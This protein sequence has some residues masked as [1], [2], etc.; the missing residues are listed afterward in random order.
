LRRWTALVATLAAVSLA[1]GCTE[2]A[3]SDRTAWQLEAHWT[4][5]DSANIKSVA[6]AEWCDSLRLLQ[7]QALHGDTGIAIALYPTRQIE[8]GRFRVVAP[9]AADSNRPVAAVALRWFAE[10]SIRG[11]QGDS[12]AVVVEQPRPGV[13]TGTFDAKAHSVTDAARL[14]I[15]GDFRDLQVRPASRGCPGRRLRSDSGAGVH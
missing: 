7:I 8:A 6:T 10:T 14:S 13:L 15:R 3:S 1:A 12:G 11:F 4:G 2:P 9:T 5:K